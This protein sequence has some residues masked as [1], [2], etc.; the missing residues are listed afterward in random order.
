M[1][2]GVLIKFVPDT[3]TK[4][5]ISG[6]G[7]GIKREGIKYVVNPYD[8]YAIEEALKLKEKTSGEGVA[9][10]AGPANATEGIRTALAMGLDRGI[11]INDDAFLT[12]DAYTTAKALESVCKQENFDIIFAGRKGIDY[13]QVQVSQML[14]SFLDIP[15]VTF[16]SKFEH[17]DENKVKVERDVDGGAKQVIE[18]NTPCIIGTT[19][20]IN[21]PRYA[22]LPG[23]MKAKKKEIKDVKL[24]DST[25]K[26]EI[27]K[28][29]LPAGR[30]KGRIL[31]GDE[32]T[33]SADLVKALREE[34][35]VI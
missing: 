24:S 14:A 30:Q 26:V 12:S 28:Y 18:I 13:D 10:C 7:S 34:A 9:I 29:A 11:H 32:A 8:E 25:A 20:G 2:I 23:I 17:L 22:S 19:K 3:E 35:K 33:A 16:V 15:S 4:I 21:E 31:E 1:K 6:E 27:K 5:E